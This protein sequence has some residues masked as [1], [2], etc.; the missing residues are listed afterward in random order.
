MRTS[1][2][3]KLSSRIGHNVLRDPVGNGPGWSFRIL[4]KALQRYVF[5][6]CGELGRDRI[7]PENIL[8][9]DSPLFHVLDWLRE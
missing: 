8:Q 3:E 9:V 2:Y 4:R 7:L 5:D 6:G 1:C